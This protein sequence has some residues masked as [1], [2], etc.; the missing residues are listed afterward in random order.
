MERL[1][2]QRTR[3][4]HSEGELARIK[5]K[6]DE[7]LTNRGEIALRRQRI[8]R[9]SPERVDH[10]GGSRLAVPPVRHGSQLI[11]RDLPSERIDPWKQTSGRRRGERLVQ[12]RDQVVRIFD[13]NRKAHDVWFSARRL[14][15]LGRK[16]PMGR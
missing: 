2:P 3:L 1:E 6:I 16:L 15:L 13:S 11:D 4:W 7:A 10:A 14:L 8:S 5:L 9:L 12:I